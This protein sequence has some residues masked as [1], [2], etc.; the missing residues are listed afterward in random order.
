M[1]KISKERKITYYIGM[2][3]VVLG[4]IL[5]VSFFFSFV[6]SMKTFEPPAFL[7]AVIGMILMIAGALVSNIGVRGAAGSGLIL[8]PE[9]ARED[10]KP[11]N[12]AKGGMINDVI[13][14]IDAIEHI[15]NPQSQKE[16]VK[17]RCRKCNTLND[18]DAKFCK[19]CGAAI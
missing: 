19:S 9:Q 14:N 8:D 16:V 17:I 13:S 1:S 12:E 18:E 2:G 7:N 3:M 4:F 5:F 6:E 11:F 10:L 15:T